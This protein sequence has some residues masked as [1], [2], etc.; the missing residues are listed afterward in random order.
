MLPVF[1]SANSGM[2]DAA[3]GKRRYEILH[4]AVAE[5]VKQFNNIRDKTLCM[6]YADGIVRPTRVFLHFFIMDGLE[7][8]LNTM[9]HTRSC[10]TCWCPD[11][12]LDETEVTSICKVA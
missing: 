11:D 1:K 3:R 5:I 6:K 10:P 12:K 7:I 2:S 8:A 4:E 9:C